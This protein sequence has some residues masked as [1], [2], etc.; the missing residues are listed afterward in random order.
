MNGHAVF[1]LDGTLIDSAPLCAEILNA[2]LIDRGA[3]GRVSAAQ[4][5]RY[6]SLG[7]PALVETLLG[8]ARGDVQADLREFRRRYAAMPTPPSSL[9]PGVR[10]GLE[11]LAARGVVLALHSNKPQGLCEKVIGELELGHLFSAI[12]GAGAGLAAKPDPAG[13][14]RALELSGGVRGRSC[15]I[16]DSELD[17]EVA[18]RAGVRL[19]MATY[20]YGERGRDWPGALLADDFAAVPGLVADL[21]TPAAPVLRAATRG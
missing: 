5:R 7:G 1:D 17:H 19:V 4:T 11:A 9:Y 3:A 20:G 6:V 21:L 18:R 12:V 16:G 10:S 13:F 14:D 2:M 15:Y 8:E